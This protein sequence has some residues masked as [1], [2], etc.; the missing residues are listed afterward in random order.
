[1]VSLRILFLLLFLEMAAGPLSAHPVYV[2]MCQIRIEANLDLQI[3]ITVFSE[4]LAR[5]IGR[6][7]LRATAGEADSLRR[8]I[9]A[10]LLPHLAFAADDQPISFA[11]GNI[12]VTPGET[13][14]VVSLTAKLKALPHSLIVRNTVFFEL[15]PDQTN[16]VRLTANGE[17]Q[18]VLLVREKPEAELLL[19]SD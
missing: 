13:R 8:Q 10:Y 19:T 15:F 5:A 11:P 6:R 14:T 16:M 9:A 1:M 3:S 17:K 4:D 7:D 12:T 18:A 2:S